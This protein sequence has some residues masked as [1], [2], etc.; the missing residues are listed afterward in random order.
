MI[1]PTSDDPKLFAHLCEKSGTAITVPIGFSFETSRKGNTET[2]LTTIYTARQGNEFGS[3]SDPV[4]TAAGIGI[5][6]QHANPALD[7][8]LSRLNGTVTVSRPTP[9]ILVM[10]KSAGGSD[11]LARCAS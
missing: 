8:L 5:D 10:Q 1:Q 6:T 9:D 7:A 4:A 2:L 3:Y 11:T